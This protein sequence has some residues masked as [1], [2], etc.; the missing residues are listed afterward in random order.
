MKKIIALLLLVVMATSLLA[1]CNNSKGNDSQKATQKEEDTKDTSDTKDTNDTKDTSDNTAAQGEVKPFKYGF[2]SWGTADEH[3]RTLNEAVRWAVEA[4]GGEF[5]MDGSA[6]SAEQTIAAAENLIQ[7]GCNMIAFCTYAGE[8]SVPQISR[9]CQENEVY[10]T[11]W[12]TTISDPDIREM[13]AQDPYYVGNT[14]EDQYNAGY[15]TM[16]VMA[17]AGA[18]NTIVIKYGVNIPTCDERVEGATAAAQEFG[19]NLLY[20]IVAPEDYKKAAQDALVAYPEADS[21]FLAGA[22]SAAPSLAAAMREAGKDKF[23]IGAFDYFDQMGEELKSGS[24]TLINGGHMVTGTF[25]ALM[26][27]NAYFGTP[28][29]DEKY[30]VTI[31]YLTLGSYDDYE[32]Y[33]QYASQGAAYTSDELKQFLKVYNPD[34]TLESFQEGVSKWSIAD[35]KER[36]GVN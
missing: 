19:V 27:I 1:G 16:K 12:D 2:I 36:K 30:M 5:V 9:L 23:Y 3:G 32:A 6:I 10:W 21:F 13:I 25:S 28:L 20:E 8:A 35:I 31:P 4:A 24:L 33:I 22:G 7:A 29:S 14:N 11:M 34:L 15:N 26:A 18:K 17:E